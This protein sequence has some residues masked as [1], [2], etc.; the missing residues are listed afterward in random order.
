M[1]SGKELLVNFSTSARGFV[2]V[3]VKDNTGRSLK[4]W[5]IFGDKVDRVIDFRDGELASFAGRPV[6]L[7]FDMSDADIYSFRFR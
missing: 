6:T 7:E 1:F 2:Y 5:E 3:T 4:S